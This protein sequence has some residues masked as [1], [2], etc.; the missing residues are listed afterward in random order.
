MLYSALLAQDNVHIVNHRDMGAK[1][2]LK[3]KIGYKKMIKAREKKRN[4]RDYRI[5]HVKRYKNGKQ[6]KKKR[7]FFF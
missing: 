3:V 7:F 5:M 4:E 6:R 2:K 1:D